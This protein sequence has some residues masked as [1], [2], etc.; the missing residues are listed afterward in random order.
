MNPRDFGWVNLVEA[1]SSKFSE[2]Q[3][4]KIRKKEIEEDIVISTSVASY[5]H[6]V[7]YIH[8]CITIKI[9]KMSHINTPPAVIIS[10]I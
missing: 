7:Y 4:Q 3:R 2:K 1:M 5:P 9:V 8:T 6:R 10:C